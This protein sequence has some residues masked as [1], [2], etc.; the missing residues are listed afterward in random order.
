MPKLLKPENAFKAPPRDSTSSAIFSW[1]RVFVP[2]TRSS[3][4]SL[5]MPLFEAVSETTPPARAAEK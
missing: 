4:I 5:V 2:L 3:D 1:D